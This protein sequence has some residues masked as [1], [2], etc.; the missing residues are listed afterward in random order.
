M[1]IYVPWLFSEVIFPS[2]IVF[3]INIPLL[4][5][6]SKVLFSWA[7]LSEACINNDI[8]FPSLMRVFPAFPIEVPLIFPS[9]L[10]FF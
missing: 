1:V 4:F 5:I 9:L 2:T 3:P 7:V 10:I 6:F 8:P